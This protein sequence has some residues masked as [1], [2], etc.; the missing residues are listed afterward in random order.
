M[1]P[2]LKPAPKIVFIIFSLSLGNVLAANHMP[3]ET[4]P[5]DLTEL[6]MESLLKLDVASVTKTSTPFVQREVYA[7]LHWNF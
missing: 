4:S 3:E 5:P 7:A 1:M 6:S 2:A